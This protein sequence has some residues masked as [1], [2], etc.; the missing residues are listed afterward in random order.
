ML[1]FPAS[2]KTSNPSAPSVLEA[3]IPKGQNQPSQIEVPDLAITPAPVSTLWKKYKIPFC[4][5]MLLASFFPNPAPMRRSLASTI[6]GFTGFSR[7]SDRT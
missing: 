2:K 1:P 4:D 3:N 7:D 6:Q 5:L